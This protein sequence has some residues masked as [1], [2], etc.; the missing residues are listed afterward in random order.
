MISTK[1]WRWWKTYVII[2]KNSQQLTSQ[3]KRKWIVLW[4]TAWIHREARMRWSPVTCVFKIPRNG[5][6]T[7]SYFFL[8]W[9]I[10]LVVS[11]SGDEACCWKTNKNSTMEENY[12]YLSTELADRK[13]NYN[14][15]T[16]QDV[17]NCT[18]PSSVKR[19]SH[20][21]SM[22]SWIPST[23][24]SRFT[25]MNEYRFTHDGVFNIRR[26]C[27]SMTWPTN[28][29]R[30]GGD[31]G[32]TGN[33]C[34]SRTYR[35]IWTSTTEIEQKEEWRILRLVFEPL[36]SQKHGHN[37]VLKRHHGYYY[38]HRHYAH[39]HRPTTLVEGMDG[40]WG[41]RDLGLYQVYGCLPSC[42]EYF[43]DG[44]DHYCTYDPNDYDRWSDGWR[45]PRVPIVVVIAVVFFHR[46]IMNPYRTQWN[47]ATRLVLS[48]C[49]NTGIYCMHA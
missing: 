13:N 20:T 5:T 36:P 19:Y 14:V 22:V 9:G 31:I 42:G 25:L 12:Y 8:F 43:P 6:Y 11:F 28:K 27:P 16:N 44:M 33:G 35:N 15:S 10:F 37:H 45:D 26:N 18:S 17:D 3:T 46:Q 47:A 21:S 32:I 48:R 4:T 24:R 40:V 23:R 34:R 1:W 7:N 29:K 30:S 39:L 41:R 49:I 38:L 2:Q